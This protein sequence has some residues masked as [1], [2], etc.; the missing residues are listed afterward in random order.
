MPPLPL[1]LVLAVA[2]SACSGPPTADIP[3][4]LEVVTGQGGGFT[5]AWSGYRLE[6]G[7][8]VER[9]TSTP[10]VDRTV[11]PVGALEAAAV[12][13]LWDRVEG[14]VLSLE[15]DEPAN[16]SR[17]LEVT[18]D[19]ATHRLT[20]EAFA[21]PDLDSLWNDLSTQFAAASL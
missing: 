3:P 18:A 4:D 17:T 1:A 10:G 19:G 5:G 11:E 8:A 9:W 21:R 15:V 20:W 6:A 13:A 7:G 2:L 16:L 14:E 12:A